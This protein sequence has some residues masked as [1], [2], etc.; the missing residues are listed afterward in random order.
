MGDIRTDTAQTPDKSA[1]LTWSDLLARAKPSPDSTIRYGADPL[2]LIDIWQPAGKGPHP[3]VIMI[4][5]GCWQ[6]E[7]AERDL[8]NWIADD[9]RKAGIGVWNIEYRGVDRGGGYPGTYLDVGQAADLFAARG[10]EFGFNTRRK[11]AIG[12]SAGGHLA[13]WLANRPVLVPDVAIRGANP[14]RIDAAVSQAGIPDLRTGETLPDHPCGA[15][16]ARQMAAGRYAET[17]P[18][19]MPQAG[20]PQYLFNTT[21]DRVAPPAYADAYLAA[22]PGA[23]VITT[24]TGNEGHVEHVA[25]DSRTW[26]EQRAL[27]IKLL[28]P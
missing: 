15:D 4:H 7:I 24:V 26:A 13:L 19:E 18:Q 27:L 1:V 6:T 2:Q 16:A 8:M 23:K 28:R 20:V 12:H 3:A 11:I 14:I 5:G 25:H 10:A 9:L 17:S 21:L 22:L